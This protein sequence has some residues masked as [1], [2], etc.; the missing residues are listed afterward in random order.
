MRLTKKLTKIFSLVFLL[1]FAVSCDKGCVA[2][3]EFDK[4]YLSINS[5]PIE[6]GIN[7]SG[8]SQ[9]ANWHDTGLKT[10]G[11]KVVIQ[12]TGGW[13]PWYGNTDI[14]GD[15]QLRILESCK[16]CSI[17]NSGTNASNNCI[18]GATEQPS[19]ETGYTGNDCA[20]NIAA[21]N[22]PT[23]CTCTT[24]AGSVT[25]YG[26]FHFPLNK[27]DKLQN[28]R[29]PDE[30]YP[31]AYRG[32]M[33]LYLGVFGS[34]GYV[35][36]KRVYHMFTTVEAC[37]VKR[38]SEGKCLDD[39]GYDVTK[40]I[41]TSAND[42]T[43][44]R[45]DNNGN[46]GYD[47]NPGDDNMHSPNEYIKMIIYDSR[48]E[49]NYGSYEVSFLSGVGSDQEKGLLEYLVRLV[50]DKIM[51]EEDEDGVRQGGIIETMFNH[52][53]VDSGFTTIVQMGLSFYIIVY[54][55]SVLIGLADVNKKELMSRIMKIALVIFFTSPT[56]WYWYNEIVVGFF[57]D[58]MDYVL[59][60][61]M[62][63]SDS[64]IDPTSGIITSQMD[65]A[66]V[67]SN[68]TRFSYADQIIRNLLSVAA[69]KKIFGLFFGVP[70][71]G[72]LY[73]IAIYG[74]IAFFIYVML[75][76]A[77]NYVV[78]MVKL[79]FGLALGPIFIAFNLSG[80]T[81]DM[82]KQWVSF[83][84]AR[85]LEVIII[86]L[87]LY[88]FLVLIDKNFTSLLYYK[89]C[90]TSWNLWLF[91]IPILKSQVDRS[92]MAWCSSIIMLAGLLY[93]TKL[94]MDKI[95]D[96]AA[97]LISIGGKGDSTVGSGS[98]AASSMT[99][100]LIGMAQS[101]GSSILNTAGNAL[102]K[103]YEGVSPIIG[104]AMS[105]AADTGSAIVRS[106]PGGNTVMDTGM[107]AFNA[108]PSN[109]RAMYRNSI[110]DNAIKEAQTNAKKNGL[111]DADADAAI[112][113]EVANKLLGQSVKYS[114][115]GN[116]PKTAAAIGLNLDSISKRLDHQLVQKPLA[117]FVRKKAKE[118]KQS[119]NAP[120]GKE[121]QS[122]INDEIAKWAKENLS[123]GEQA[124][125]AIMND[126]NA[127]VNG[128]TS[129][130]FGFNNMKEFI[131]N[132]SQY[133]SSEA[134]RAFVNNPEKQS[135][136]LQ[137]LQ[138]NEARNIRKREERI[139]SA[140]N[141][142]GAYGVFARLSNTVRDKVDNFV[143]TVK[144]I[145][146]AFGIDALHD[147]SRSKYS[148][149]RKV[150]NLENRDPGSV[151]DLLAAKTGSWIK[152]NK[153]SAL[154]PNNLFKRKEDIEQNV[155]QGTRIG[156]LN[157]LAKN[158]LQKD[159]DR[160]KT[161]YGK[162]ENSAPNYQAKQAFV[163]K[164]NEKLEKARKQ[165]DIFKDQLGKNA[166]KMTFSKPSEV[167]SDLE[168]LSK[169]RQELL[170]N[171][172]QRKALQYL[173]EFLQ[174]SE[175]A[176]SENGK[177]NPNQRQQLDQEARKDEFERK[178]TALD[179]E[180]ESKIKEATD[181]KLKVLGLEELTKE[182]DKQMKQSNSKAN[183]EEEDYWK[184]I[185]KTLQERLESEYKTSL[186]Q[187][188]E[189]QR[190]FMNQQALEEVDKKITEA[191]ANGAS[192]KDFIKV[193]EV[194]R[195]ALEEKFKSPKN[196]TEEEELDKAIKDLPQNLRTKLLSDRVGGVEALKNGFTKLED[197]S[198]LFEKSA[199]LRFFLEK[200]ED[201]QVENATTQA[202][203]NLEFERGVVE[204]NIEDD[205]ITERDIEVV[206]EDGV[207]NLLHDLEEEIN[208]KIANNEDL[209]QELEN[210]N[211]IKNDLNSDRQNGTEN[212]ADQQ[213][214]N[215]LLIRV[216]DIQIR[217]FESQISQIRKIN[218]REQQEINRLRLIANPSPDQQMEIRNLQDAINNRNQEINGLNQQIG[219]TRN[220]RVGLN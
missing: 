123:G 29:V 99:G 119:N 137:S 23:K 173:P 179:A 38:N 33:G 109:P 166:V 144:P 98:S 79:A 92:L 32:G 129:G 203:E 78:S 187:Q 124:L 156:L 77:M 210:L 81:S 95:P 184:N 142:K 151:T 4:E 107:R 89:A 141:A 51:G 209:E 74:L 113:G 146:D 116:A 16:F 176:N 154:N 19:S 2:E 196:E 62:S 159:K 96:L 118:L 61:L 104:Q 49:D 88:N 87:V 204:N 216:L 165:F 163:K 110:I 183:T 70:I 94:I 63:L 13:T 3:Q 191:Q 73:I 213:Q 121:M 155:N 9:I 208:I 18:C 148:F 211:Q 86:F 160:I 48:Y 85:S 189:I 72:P 195:T 120:I 126:K 111:K 200:F 128:M 37:D 60:F 43:F 55:A 69:A 106:L 35:T 6:D 177:P 175:G 27:F 167:S 76:T 47:P 192:I 164:K 80:H 28:E 31:C 7:G 91:S 170:E 197:D 15:P 152:Y 5:R 199:R 188:L 59:S 71:F 30:Q 212:P 214:N 101:A 125:H 157:Y 64:N 180:R 17:N 68:S 65:R 26:V 153:G 132:Q 145:D 190:E 25:D 182:I 82:F 24:T 215:Q 150:Q 140:N 42:T 45:D 217:V 194:A 122:K 20:T 46:Q 168:K 115:I 10:D 172:K 193:E 108:M 11:N 56:S 93:I 22:D 134:A 147:T 36:P 50:E 206:L 114:S 40:Y 181:L 54:G 112:R 207:E 103:G 75:F 162:K 161:E 136:Y 143:K 171:Y 117:D 21:Q 205:Q 34:N 52:I 202:N 130:G 198:T 102:A 8:S 53:V 139:E 83:I 158:G 169:N 57:K 186:V 201:R 218:D 12:L 133:T 66:T 100:G 97:S 44:V 220:E 90:V 131:R 39:N 178:K 219:D 127:V 14:S 58:G 135:E 138:E 105:S 41:F 185:K 149:L 84:G 1:L 67:G 174:K